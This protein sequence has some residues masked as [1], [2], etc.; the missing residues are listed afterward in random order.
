MKIL[1]IVYSL[2]PDNFRGGISKVV[3]E[4]GIAQVAC[5]HAVEVYTTNINGSDKINVP[6]D[7]PRII[8]GLV[9]NYY[10]GIFF[11]DFSSTDLK[12]SLM[13]NANKFDVI[14]SHCNYLSFNRYAANA[15]KLLGVPTF[16][17]THGCYDPVLIKMG[18]IKRLKKS[19][20][21]P[22]IEVPNMNASSGV[23]VCNNDELKQLRHYNVK[24]PLIEISNGTN[25]C[26][27]R[28]LYKNN[29]FRERFNISADKRFIFYI[30]RIHPIKQLDLLIN[31]FN[32]IQSQIP[33]VILIIAGD[34]N[35]C[36]S[37]VK[38][39]DVII[40][41]AKIGNKI[42]W[43][44]YLNESDKIE[45]LLESTIFSYV[46][47]REG[48]SIAILEGMALGVPTIVGVGCHM[49]KAVES[50]ALIECGNSK[51]ELAS[52]YMEVLT[53]K[54]LQNKLCHRAQQFTSTFYTW[55]K[56]AK[57]C[58]NEYSKAIK[59]KKNLQFQQ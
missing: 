22:T 42:Y 14:H 29:T 15:C 35:Q 18:L 5:G 11:P 55:D 40:K 26:G 12:E 27:T 57:K 13:K 53:N 50:E 44:G 21:I 25:L 49:S 52:I 17:H 36:P 34:R 58:I 43:C 32:E 10:N 7:K 24:V 23:F 39:I 8:N 30:G 9:I 54:N 19:L 33:D 6:L 51:D 20:Y 16:F 56:I 41:K 45:A 48:M 37:Y 59:L 38:K 28:N 2:V 1:H 46:S 4:L 47:S 31:A 3:F